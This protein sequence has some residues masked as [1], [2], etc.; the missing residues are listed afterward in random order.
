MYPLIL[1]RNAR[2]SMVIPITELLESS[3]DLTGKADAN[4]RLWFRVL[5][6]QK[7]GRVLLRFS[8]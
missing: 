7:Y 8:M 1:S 3:I 5:L 4:G 2:V 6:M